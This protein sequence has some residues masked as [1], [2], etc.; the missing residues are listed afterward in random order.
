MIRGTN[1]HQNNPKRNPAAQ[2]HKKH[3]RRLHPLFYTTVLL[4]LINITLLCALS[5]LQ[6][7]ASKSQEMEASGEVQT[8]Q[9]ASTSNDSASEEAAFSEV[10]DEELAQECQEIYEDSEEL[11][12][13]VNK[14][15]AL[16]DDYQIELRL[17]NNERMYLAEVLYDDLVKMLDDASDEGYSY[18]LV[19]GYRD[20]EYQQGLL[21]QDVEMYMKDYGMTREKALEKA[22][23]QVMPAGYSEHETGLALDITAAGKPVLDESQASEP[24]ILWLYENSWKYGFILRYPE[25]KEEIT[26]ISY[27]PWHFRYVGYEAAKFLYEHDMALEEFYEY[28]D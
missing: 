23:E 5:G 12:V 6:H 24:A 13:L 2:N 7:T 3:R 10:S 14:D 26:Q 9:A 20:S 22:L 16:A 1:L 17:L 19:S 25:D 28:L 11:L 27:E 8:S 15:H 4:I 21:E 18:Y